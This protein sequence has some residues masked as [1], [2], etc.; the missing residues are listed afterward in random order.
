[1]VFLTL[2]NSELTNDRTKDIE[3]KV[4]GLEE[5]I[6]DSKPSLIEE[7]GQKFY[8]ING[9]RAYVEIDGKLAGRYSTNYT[10]ADSL[11]VR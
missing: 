2:I 3:K 7:N 6:Q 8:K 5:K 1:M 9:Y 10:K 11:E 4:A